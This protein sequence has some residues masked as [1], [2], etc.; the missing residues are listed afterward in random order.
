MSG[1]QPV[2]KI[3]KT[4][5]TANGVQL[6]ENEKERQRVRRAAGREGEEHNKEQT[7]IVK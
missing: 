1:R 3:Q 7:L 2:Q 6:K 4:Q 5:K